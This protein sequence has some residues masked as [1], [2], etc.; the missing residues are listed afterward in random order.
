M[1]DAMNKIQESV[2]IIIGAT[3][4]YVAPKVEE[5]LKKRK[6]RSSF[7]DTLKINSSVREELKSLKRTLKASRVSIMD[8]HNGTT[9]YTGLPFNFI[10]MSHE[11]MSDDI[12]SIQKDIQ[13]VP[14]APFVNTLL[15]LESNKGGYIRV[16]DNDADVSMSLF[17]KA[18]GIKTCYMFK[19]G[20]NLIDGVLSIDWTDKSPVLTME[21]KRHAQATALKI[22]LLLSKV[23]KH[24]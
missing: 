7:I 9:T 23:R 6:K 22:Q 5:Y 17:N 13:F 8:Y 11:C 3:V 1:S 19:L 24:R 10:S 14:I 15:T 16:T 21:E 20:P 2:G 18:Y 12:P 4:L